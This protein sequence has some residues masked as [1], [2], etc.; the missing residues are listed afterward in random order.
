[1]RNGHDEALALNP[2]DSNDCLSQMK[3][4]LRKRRLVWSSVGLVGLAAGITLFAVAMSRRQS[5]SSSTSFQN[6]RPSGQEDGDSGCVGDDCFIEQTSR[7]SPQPTDTPSLSPTYSP[8]SVPSD[9]P[10]EIPSPSPSTFPS[11]D[12][13]TLPSQDPSTY[14]SASPSQDPSDKPSPKPSRIPTATPSFRPSSSPTRSPTSFPTSAEPTGKPTRIEFNPG[15]LTV[16]ED[17]LLLSTGLT[18]RLLATTGQHVRFDNGGRSQQVFHRLPDYGATFPDP[19]SP[20]GWIYTSNSEV[21]SHDGL[22]QGGV[23]A[24]TFNAAGELVDYK[25]IL[26]ETTANCGGGKT[27]WGAFISCEE[28]ANGQVWQVDPTGMR[29]P[30]VIT[31]GRDGGLFESF[32]YDMRYPQNPA[33]F[34]TED[35]KEGAL[36]RFRPDAPNWKDPWNILLGSGTI[37]YLVLHPFDGDNLGLGGT[38]EWSSNR[39]KAKQSAKNHYPNSE[40]I[41]IRHGELFFVSKRHKTMMTLDL[42]EGTYEVES[43]KSG[44]FN[45]GPDQIKRILKDNSN[46][47]FFTEDGGPYAG[48]HA[49]NERG[50]YIT[51]LESP[52]HYPETTGL[53]FSPD[54][55]RMYVAYQG[56]GGADALESNKI[57]YLYEIRREDGLPFNG[58]S[59]NVNYHANTFA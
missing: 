5:S 49:R 38:F 10:S 57:G 32:A 23:G 46:L 37:D 30:A 9:I 42:D 45:G 55:R 54:G 25:R 26:N 35:A 19:S 47:L 53:A 16:S 33:F 4:S 58:R 1:M 22:G 51:I 3:G 56:D 2:V 27:P 24:F 52:T 50:E 41:D 39:T 59:L 28:F 40:G 7:R 6:R 18:S 15:D 8:S 12:P 29:A 13:S 17:N 31:L 36:Q 20:G 48:I 21:R 43:T 44:L 11:M 14:P 34:V